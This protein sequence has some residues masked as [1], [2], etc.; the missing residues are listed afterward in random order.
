MKDIFTCV[1]VYVART[2]FFK[3][4]QVRRKL[5]SMKSMQGPALQVDPVSR[6]AIPFHI[7]K[8]SVLSRLTDWRLRCEGTVK[9][10]YNRTRYALSE[11]LNDTTMT[12]S[13]LLFFPR[14]MWL[15]DSSKKKKKIENKVCKFFSKE[16]FF[17]KKITFCKSKI[18]RFNKA[19]RNL[20]EMEQLLQV[21]N[22]MELVLF[23]ARIIVSFFI[24]FIFF[25]R[26]YRSFY[27]HQTLKLTHA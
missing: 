7:E 5:P 2:H 6:F 15:P 21:H 22:P 11:D 26:D 17:P 1:A 20:Q 3:Y 13:L 24:F 8:V 16:K 12:E 10:K 27:C 4:S 23:Q 19:F 18:D 9:W 14:T 25:A